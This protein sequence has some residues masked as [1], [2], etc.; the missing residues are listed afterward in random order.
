MPSRLR[1][2]AAGLAALQI[3]DAIASATP[4]I[5]MAARLDHFGVPG[6]LWPGLPV[7][8]VSTSVGLLVGPRRPWVGAIALPLLLR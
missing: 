6:V 7:I 2:L 4:Q 3:V 1:Q 8:K 5:S